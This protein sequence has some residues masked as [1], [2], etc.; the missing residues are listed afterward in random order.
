MDLKIIV[1]QSPILDDDAKEVSRT[2]VR[3]FELFKF[4]ICNFIIF[5]ETNIF[6]LQPPVDVL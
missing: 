2:F 5:L 6:K 3:L 4:L 1:L